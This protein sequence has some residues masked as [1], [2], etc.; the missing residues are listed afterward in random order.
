MIIAEAEVPTIDAAALG[1]F[2]GRAF[3]RE[4][5]H[6]GPVAGG[7]KIMPANALADARG[8]GFNRSFFGGDRQGEK[9]GASAC[10]QRLIAAALSGPQQALGKAWLAPEKVADTVDG[11]EVRADADDHG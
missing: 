2:S 9:A 5:R 6:A 1:Q 11:D 3:G 8:E 4:Q 10:R 7:G